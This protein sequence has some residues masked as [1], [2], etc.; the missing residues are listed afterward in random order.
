MFSGDFVKINA[1]NLL[2]SDEDDWSEEETLLLL[3]GI[4]MFDENWNKVSVS[5]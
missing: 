2:K 4:E 5:L 3:E 1:A